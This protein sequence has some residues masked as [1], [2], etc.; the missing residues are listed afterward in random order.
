MRVRLLKETYANDLKKLFEDFKNDKIRKKIEYL[1]DDIYDIG[2]VEP[3]PIYMASGSE[4]E[5]THDFMEAFD[6]I[7]KYYL[8]MDRDLTMD[9]RFWHT[10]FMVNF[11]EYIIEK[12][13]NVIKSQNDFNNI[14]VK[15][16]HWE[17]YIYKSL[18]AVQYINETTN[19]FQK[20]K[21]YSLIINNLDLYNYIIKYRIYRNGQFLK[22]ILDIVN[23][24]DLS[25]ISKA[26]IKNHPDLGDDE[27]YGRRVIFELNKMYPVIMVPMLDKNELTKL[28]K[29]I[30]K[31]YEANY[32]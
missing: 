1:S 20:D 19:G 16:F 14:L 25:K 29:R 22:M 8:Y 10:L 17:N 9:K 12:H 23:D 11:R 5:K 28:F 18:L 4:D 2:N 13:P 27:R 32:E 26:K 31:K 15:K 6:K 30:L 7:E 21:Y 24:E 3:F